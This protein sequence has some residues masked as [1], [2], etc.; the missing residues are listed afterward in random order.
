MRKWR[1]VPRDMRHDCFGQAPISTALW[2][3]SG[4][5]GVPC[6]EPRNE[7]RHFCLFVGRGRIAISYR[8]VT[9]SSPFHFPLLPALSLFLSLSLVFIPAAQLFFLFSK[10]VPRKRE[11]LGY[12]DRPPPAFSTGRAW[13]NGYT[14][15]CIGAGIDA[16]DTARGCSSSKLKPI[17]SFANPRQDCTL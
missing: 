16:V 8:P 5:C 6:I 2:A 9:G 7:R 1:N 11:L 13:Y 17:F 14:V 12:R 4:I 15:L 10:V 3:T